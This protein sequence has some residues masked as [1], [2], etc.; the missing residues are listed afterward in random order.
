MLHPGCTVERHGLCATCMPSCH[1]Q[2]A[3]A[4]LWLSRRGWEYCLLATSPKPEVYHAIP[5]AAASGATR[6]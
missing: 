4:D 1:L 3:P 2:G 6:L 5:V